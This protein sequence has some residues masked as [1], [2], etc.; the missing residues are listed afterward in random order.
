MSDRVGK[1]KAAAALL[2]VIAAAVA[3]AG[4]DRSQ[5]D[6]LEEVKRT[7]ARQKQMLEEAKKSGRGAAVPM[8]DL[9]R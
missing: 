7:E 9:D 4:C 2:A 6:A 1:V 8:F 3:L 5:A